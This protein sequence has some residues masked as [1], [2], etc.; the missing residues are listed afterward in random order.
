MVGRIAERIVVDT[1]DSSEEA[2]TFFFSAIS[3]E[4][5]QEYCGSSFEIE[6]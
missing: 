2:S 6:N 1:P 4:S 3:F 5:F